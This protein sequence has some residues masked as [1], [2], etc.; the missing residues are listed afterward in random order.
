ME[1]DMK[2]IVIA[3]VTITIGSVVRILHENDKVRIKANKALLIYA[4]SLAIGYLCYDLAI[5]YDKKDW[6]GF[7][8]ILGGIISIDLVNLIIE[9]LPKLI[10]KRFSKKIDNDGDSI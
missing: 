7:A 4:C 2:L 9:Q 6:L 1:I 8:G 10:M 5:I 3:F